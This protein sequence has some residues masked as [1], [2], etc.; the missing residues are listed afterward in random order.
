MTVSSRP[1]LEDLNELKNGVNI[2]VYHRPDDEGP[3]RSQFIDIATAAEL[4]G[5]TS[6]EIS[7]KPDQQ[8]MKDVIALE[9]LLY[10]NRKIHAYYQKASRS[11]SL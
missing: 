1:V 5:I 11:I 10:G 7:F 9:K 2:V 4:L 8:T 3:K 6:I